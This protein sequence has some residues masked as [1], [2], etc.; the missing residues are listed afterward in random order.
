[1]SCLHGY[2][3][4]F[5]AINDFNSVARWHNDIKQIE[6]RFSGAASTG[7]LSRRGTITTNHDEKDPQQEYQKALKTRSRQKGRKEGLKVDF[8]HLKSSR[9]G[10]LDGDEEQDTEI[11]DL[12][13]T[14]LVSQV[15]LRGCGVH[16]KPDTNKPLYRSNFSLKTDRRST[17]QH[18]VT[19]VDCMDYSEELSIIAIGGV[20]GKIGILDGRTLLCNAL[21]DAHEAEIVG[22]NFFDSQRQLISIAKDGELKLWDA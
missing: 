7:T 10:L 18:S 12:I 21:I 13:S 22:L 2:V 15:K 5:D 19:T 6:N 20:S 16:E 8:S 17:K 4:L 11:K 1:M 3:E 14:N 9:S